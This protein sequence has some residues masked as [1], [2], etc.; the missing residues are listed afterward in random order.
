MFETL[1][2]KKLGRYDI[3]NQ[4][5]YGGMGAV[6]KSHDP[7]LNREVAVKVMH[8]HLAQSPQFRE[9]F[10]RE[11]QAM[12]QLRHPGLVQIF[13]FGE[14]DSYLYLVMELILPLNSIGRNLEDR[15]QL[16]KN[17]GKQLSL[18]E[19]LH[20]MR[21]VC[22]TLDYAHQKNI[23]HRDLKPSNILLHP[24]P[25]G[26]LPYR[27]IIADLGLAKIIA[28]EEF[29]HT[30]TPV[31]TLVYT[32]PELF[33]NEPP[34]ARSDIYT[35]GVILYELVVGQLP[36]PITSLAEALYYHTQVQPTFSSVNPATTPPQVEAIILK[37]MA[38]QPPQRFATV[39][40]MAKEL[41]RVITLLTPPSAESQDCNSQPSPQPH[42][43]LSP[44]QSSASP[45]IEN[46]QHL[47]LPPEVYLVLEA[48][49]ADY[50]RVVIK[51]ELGG[52]LSGGRVLAVRPIPR[53]NTGE[54]Q[55]VVKLAAISLIEKEWR[56]Y[57]QYIA[58]RLTNIADILEPPTLLSHIGWG[59]L[60]YL[61]AGG[62]A[63]SISS[64]LDY[65]RRADITASNVRDLA[66]RLIR[67]MYNIWG[68]ASPIS[69]FRLSESYDHL[70]PVSLLIK[71][72]IQ[73]EDKKPTLISPDTP[74]L[75]SIQ[76]ETL[77][78]II[79]FAVK[80]VDLVNDTVT[81]KP[82][83][84]TKKNVPLVRISGQIDTLASYGADQT[85]Q[86]SL[87]GVIL[88]TRNSRLQTEINHAIGLPDET[89][90]LPVP[91]EPHHLRHPLQALPTYLMQSRDVKIAPIHGDFNLENI[92]IEV[93]TNHIYLIDFAEARRDHVLHDF[94]R[95]ETEIMTK[96]VAEIIHRHKLNPA[97]T[98]NYF[99]HQLESSLKLG[100]II[101]EKSVP[102]LTHPDLAK[103]FAL[104]KVLREA[105]RQYLPPDD[106]TEYYQS[107]F[108]YLLGAMKF[109]NL[110]TP[111]DLAGRSI[112]K[113][114]AFWGA[115]I[116]DD[117]MRHPPLPP[118]PQPMLPE[119]K[120]AKNFITD[121]LIYGILFLLGVVGAIVGIVYLIQ[122][123]PEAGVI[124]Q[125]MGVNPVVIVERVGTD[126][127]FQ[128]KELCEPLYHGDTLRIEAGALV[129]YACRETGQI[130]ELSGP[131]ELQIT[132]Q[133]D[134]QGAK[135]MARAETF[136]SIKVADLCSSFSLAELLRTRARST[137]A[138]HTMKPFLLNPRN[139]VITD[140]RPTFNWQ[141]VEGAGSY[142]LEVTSGLESWSRE[143]T[144]TTLA[145]PK[146][147]TS[148]EIGSTHTI[149]LSIVDSPETL[150]KSVLQVATENQA[151]KLARTQ[152]EIEA[153]DFNLATRNNLQLE[154]YRQQGFSMAAIAYLEHLIAKQ[155]T[156]SPVLFQQLGDLHFNI[157]LYTQAEVAYQAALNTAKM[158]ENLIAQADAY[159]GLASVQLILEEV[160]QAKNNLLT[161]E[162]LYNKGGD[163]NK[164]ETTAKM[165]S[166]LN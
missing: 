19:A 79:G 88:E 96:L 130:I 13:D 133:T 2:G 78:K 54:L 64:L 128:P 47:T 155:S 141:A 131:Q 149:R 100:A 52:G 147:E 16:L 69:E 84:S 95:F 71:Q 103:P 18:T 4:L 6:F 59:G 10:R 132:C 39:G 143:I 99:Y 44:D 65:C 111:T 61:M 152:A 163:K 120:Q 7:D 98:L 55:T 94:L 139:S 72:V 58:R 92:L 56:A 75:E 57:Q 12:A 150:D 34:D 25:T 158:E 30:P 3:I 76:L 68:Q 161:A 60:K 45:S 85:L 26:P 156:P 104:L 101:S 121:K 35:L 164:A 107:L 51:R 113:Q 117:L 127:T 24:E 83:P 50:E 90:S 93:E 81:L 23:I 40:E 1:S 114:V 15:L 9:R 28:D 29:T 118:L 77:V 105:A 148:L 73:P 116:I 37:A 97:Q 151:D 41:E 157:E 102:D 109:D 136:R 144:D 108:L 125:T 115:V 124:A 20:F 110:N 21:E 160:E 74:Q 135:E 42:F 17:Q 129:S 46:P 49:F 67:I 32:S 140:T 80:K 165:R 87:I 70:L 142:R 5:G 53:G 166:E 22:T 43:H 154:S 36:F 106:Y 8:D 63:F 122:T 146:D 86:E 66:N 112:P 82:P 162:G 134:A 62:G 126:Q 48:M 153:S 159:V 27:P 11:A 123:R 138:E 38:K 14:Q 89:G 33:R 137:R 91:G 145:Y 119:S 31:G